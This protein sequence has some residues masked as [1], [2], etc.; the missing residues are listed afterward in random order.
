MLEVLDF[1]FKSFWTF[2]GTIFLI[3]VLGDF[4]HDFI[5]AFVPKIDKSTHYHID[6]KELNMDE[7]RAYINMKENE[8]E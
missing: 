3:A 8:D 5:S 6:G 7:V 4:V 2:V 1:I